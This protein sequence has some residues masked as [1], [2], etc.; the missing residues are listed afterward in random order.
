MPE[1]RELAPPPHL[2]DTIECVWS[3]R[4]SGKSAYSHRV[5][6]DGCADIL[7]TSIGARATLQVVGP[8]TKFEDI[9]LPPRVLT[10]GIRFRP[11]MWTNEIG[12]PAAG[13]T[14]AL[15]PLDN[16]WGVRASTLLNQ[17]CDANSFEDCAA[18]LTQ[19]IRAT[20]TLTPVQHAIAWMEKSRGQASLDWLARQAALSTRQ[21]RRVCIQQTGLS[22][23]FLA[24]VLRFRHALSK[25]HAAAGGH[26][27]LAAECGYADQSHFIAEFRHFSGRAPTEFLRSQA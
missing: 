9:P 10:L 3:L 4:H 19:S 27:G 23:K 16:V 12:V 18:L 1:Y 22:P 21:F 15:L 8:M 2:T 20:G 17:L 26:A 25:V 24:R 5:V 13:I 11:G 6:P 7:F 14:D